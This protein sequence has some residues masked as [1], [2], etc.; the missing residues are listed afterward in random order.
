MFAVFG[1]FPER[2]CGEGRRAPNL[3]SPLL[4][5]TFGAPLCGGR[6]SREHPAQP[7]AAGAPNTSLEL[8][9]PQRAVAVSMVTGGP[10]T[11]RADS[12]SLCLRGNRHSDTPASV[13][14]DCPEQRTEATP[15]VFLTPPRVEVN[16]E[17]ERGPSAT[18]PQEGQNR[19][20]I[21]QPRDSRFRPTRPPVPPQKW[22]PASDR[23]RCPCWEALVLLVCRVGQSWRPPARD[24]VKWAP[25][26]R[27][28]PQGGKGSRATSVG[29]GPPGPSWGPRPR[30][31]VRL[32]CASK[33]K[34]LEV[35][36]LAG[37]ALP[38]CGLDDFKHGPT[39][40]L[41]PL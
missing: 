19:D 18:H 32:C 14:G 15:G 17:C 24:S 34:P 2:R 36:H 41:K 35:L 33:S 8:C 25:L 23:R 3:P 7:E 26:P 40:V 5:G 38:T 30:V 31:G 1:R 29:T 39:Q 21:R 9:N 16:L 37:Q 22:M 13:R 28:G 6:G 4:S 12:V 11:K 20:T 10:L 27:S